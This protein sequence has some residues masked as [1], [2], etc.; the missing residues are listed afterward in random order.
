MTTPFSEIF[1]FRSQNN[2]GQPLLLVIKVENHDSSEAGLRVLYQNWSITASSFLFV[3]TERTE[4]H[5]TKE[6]S[7]DITQ[8]T[9]NQMKA[10]SEDCLDETGTPLDLE[11][12][13]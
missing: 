10:D 12:L 3:I 2:Q 6:R 13:C 1:I 8:E 11:R 5:S 7:W 4:A 9:H